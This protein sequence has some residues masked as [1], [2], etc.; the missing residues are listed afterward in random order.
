MKKSIAFILRVFA[1]FIKF[2]LILFLGFYYPLEDVGLYGVL[3]ALASYS[4]Y[5]LGFELHAIVNR[6]GIKSDGRWPALIG[7]QFGV[8]IVTA[9][10]FSGAVILISFFLENKI[11]CYYLIMLGLIE[12]YGQE[13]Y[14]RY[15]ALRRQF[16]A[17]VFLFIKNGL[18]PIA[19]ISYFYFARH[20]PD[21]DAVFMFW[22]I[23]GSLSVLM[24]G[25]HMRLSIFG[26]P[27]WP[28]FDWKW[29]VETLRRVSVFLASILIIR[30]I[31][32]ADRIL[33][34][35]N[36]SGD[37]LGLY[38]FY[39]SLAAALGAVLNF[40][41]AAQSYPKLI[42]AISE[43]NSESYDMVKKEMFI[44]TMGIAVVGVVAAP[45]FLQ[46]GYHFH[47]NPLLD[48]NA[49]KQLFFLILSW[50]PINALNMYFHYVLYCHGGDRSILASNLIGFFAALFFMAI[51][52]VVTDLNAPLVAVVVLVFYSCGTLS[53]AI[54][55]KKYR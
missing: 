13:I 46:L 17:S 9:I 20:R 38:V 47:D 48:L 2:V 8:S 32:V 42:M 31:N 10:L 43:S 29:F 36:D 49:N 28:T 54:Y 44:N 40:V 51:T 1:L 14:R 35:V 7:K 5:F 11:Y 52:I 19:F 53:K 50:V 22:I 23:T 12:Y 30:S 6:E 41:G 18:W 3:S 37:N 33:V 25:I 21:I 55:L 24:A 15:I 34:G 4:I 27:L 16:I 45:L 39:S 26:D